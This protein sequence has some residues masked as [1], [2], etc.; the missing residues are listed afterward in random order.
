MSNTD[1]QQNTTT[2]Q[3]HNGSLLQW[4]L[5]ILISGSLLSG[6]V[7]TVI[8]RGCQ[9]Q[10]NKETNQTT[11]YVADQQHQDKQEEISL[12]KE[13]DCKVAT[14]KNYGNVDAV[15]EKLDKYVFQ[16]Q[17]MHRKWGEHGRD[18]SVFDEN[19]QNQ[20]SY[21]FNDLTFIR[22]KS[23]GSKEG[24]ALKDEMEMWLIT[25]YPGVVETGAS[26]SSENYHIVTLAN[27]NE[28]G[29]IETPNAGRLKD[30]EDK[31]D[32]YMEYFINFI[33]GE[34]KDCVDKNK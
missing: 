16:I 1:N 30:L 15:R 29:T 28:Q 11:R 7:G 32:A 21:I 19:D 13:R 10:D 24:Q 17:E 33:E 12:E 23:K 5:K 34:V 26:F 4:V 2:E 18:I 25:F 8:N 3:N 27:V 14:E 9:S 20:I 6:L 31:K 22:N